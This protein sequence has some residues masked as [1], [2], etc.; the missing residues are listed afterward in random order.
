MENNDGGGINFRVGEVDER[1]VVD[2]CDAGET[3]LFEGGVFDAI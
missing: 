2:N 1:D 3:V